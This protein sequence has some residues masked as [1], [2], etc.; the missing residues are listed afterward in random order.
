MLEYSFVVVDVNF[1]LYFPLSKYFKRK[2]NYVCVSAFQTLNEA[3]EFI[4]EG[5]ID[6]LFVS[7]NQSNSVEIKSLEK[8]ASQ[9]FTI[10]I[11]D[12]SALL[13][14]FVHLFLD[15][16]KILCVMRQE[17]FANISKVVYRFEKFQKAQRILQRIEEFF[18]NQPLFFPLRTD[19]KQLLLFN[20]I[21]FFR[22]RGHYIVA[23]TIFSKEFV[24]RL[25]LNELLKIIPSQIFI[26]LQRNFIANIHQISAFTDISVIIDNEVYNV[27][28]RRRKEVFGLLSA[29]RSDLQKVKET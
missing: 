10:L 21:L 29:L 5:K 9:P 4:K 26:Q 7:L 14:H 23:R 6:L 11:T 15:N 12:T 13:S 17:L 25:T 1:L 16:H 28:H 18:E 19:T 27:A 20:E 24:F 22:C 2:G 8:L 3:F